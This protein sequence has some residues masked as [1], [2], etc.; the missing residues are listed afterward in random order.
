MPITYSV[1]ACPKGTTDAQAI[2]TK[3]ISKKCTKIAAAKGG[4]PAPQSV[5][6]IVQTSINQYVSG[7]KRDV[8]YVSVKMDAQDTAGIYGTSN[9]NNRAKPLVVAVKVIDTRAPEISIEGSRKI[10]Y[11]CGAKQVVNYE[12]MGATYV[13]QLDRCETANCKTR[14]AA[15]LTNQCVAGK[16]A[17]CHFTDTFAQGKCAPQ[18]SGKC[19]QGRV[20]GNYHVTYSATDHDSNTQTR[21]RQITV[22]DTTNPVLTLLGSK[23]GGSVY[24]T[25][26]LTKSTNTDDSIESV[27]GG[28]TV[29]DACDEHIGPAQV[30]KSWGKIPFNRKMVGAYIRT[31]TATDAAG[32][33]DTQKRTF[34][35][36]DQE[37]PV[38]TMAGADQIIEATRASEYMDHGATCEDFVDGVLN[39]RVKVS[40]DI[41]DLTV[42]GTYKV[43]YDCEDLSGRKAERVTRTVVVQ[44][45]T[46]PEIRANGRTQQTVEAGFP[47]VDEGATAT[48]TLDGEIL[49]C[50][51]ESKTIVAGDLTTQKATPILKSKTCLR[52]VGDSVNEYFEYNSRESCAEIYSA[53]QQGAKSGKYTITAGSKNLKKVNVLCNMDHSLKQKTFL[54]VH[55][56]NADH[57]KRYA[58]CSALGMKPVYG[59]DAQ[60]KEFFASST[61]QLAAFDP[62]YKETQVGFMC[63][64]KDESAPQTLTQKDCSE[65]DAAHRC[66]RSG[67]YYIKYTTKDLVG[68]D[69]KPVTRKVHVIDSLPPVISLHFKAT[70]GIDEQ[71]DMDR[72]A[73]VN[74]PRKEYVIQKSKGGISSADDHEENPASSPNS[75]PHLH[76]TVE[77]P[78]LNLMAE[79]TSSANAW[80]IGAAASAVA[81][82]ALLAASSKKTVTSVPV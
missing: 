65:D 25:R 26:Y 55:G 60:D 3:Y 12:D 76:N 75:N 23:T 48:D 56:I 80:I 14:G 38:V 34:W 51:V 33:S 45:T 20:E 69:A 79:T 59:F 35:V 46:A 39:H 40:G 4:S 78:K 54:V 5:P 28:F 44:D 71:N 74:A 63:T 47:Y 53:S 6:A 18:Y 62:K 24:A 52:T 66:T 22:K 57:A 68:L 77:Y 81:G 49:G 58:H 8:G 72:E 31:Y 11:E 70:M 50:D 41:V 64:T 67:T 17:Y 1:F 16:T 21:T 13:E 36:V 2:E 19:T 7:N 9:M 73:V 61:I 37:Q 43:N 42:V 15:A 82:V 10:A 32:N 29:T 30:T 27:D